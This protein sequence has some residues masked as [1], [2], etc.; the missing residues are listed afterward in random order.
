MR[1]AGHD[2]EDRTG[3]GA[4]PAITVSALATGKNPSEAVSHSSGPFTRRV[5]AAGRQ[6][7]TAPTDAIGGPGR[8][9]APWPGQRHDPTWAGGHRPGPRPGERNRPLTDAPRSD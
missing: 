5:H 6:P 9:P 2:S 4:R 1:G 8:W 7:V 3:Q